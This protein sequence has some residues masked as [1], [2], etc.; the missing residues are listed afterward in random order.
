MNDFSCNIY[1]NLENFTTEQQQRQELRTIINLFSFFHCCDN[2]V[3]YFTMKYD[4]HNVY[5]AKSKK[6][7]LPIFIQSKLNN[8]ER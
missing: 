7:L 3:D 1:I 4:V 6:N 5:M 2:T 8:D